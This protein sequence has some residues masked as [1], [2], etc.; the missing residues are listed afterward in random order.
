MGVPAYYGRFAVVPHTL[1][2][3]GMAAF[4]ADITD[5]GCLPPHPATLVRVHLLR[6]YMTRLPAHR[7]YATVPVFTC[8]VFV[9]FYRCSWRTV[10]VRFPVCYRA[11]AG[12]GMNGVYVPRC[13]FVHGSARD[14][15]RQ[16]YLPL[17][18]LCSSLVFCG[19]H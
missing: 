11:F 6:D 9:S 3:R 18:P 15:A 4:V 10:A 14:W 17:L 5:S 7:V 1:R 8:T 2:V 12:D 16:Q 19:V 13:W